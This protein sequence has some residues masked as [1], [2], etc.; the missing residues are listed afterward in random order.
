[1]SHTSQRRGLDP[2]KPGEEL[3]VIAMVPN[4]YR[5]MAEINAAMYEIGTKMLEYSPDN[6]LMKNFTD[7]TIPKFGFGQGIM[8]FLHQYWPE[9][10]RKLLMRGVSKSSLIITAL[11]TDTKK[12]ECLINDLKSEWLFRNRKEG[13][14]ISLVLSGLPCDIHT[15]CEQNKIREHTYLHSLGF[16][17]RQ[18]GI[19]T[20]DKLSLI[21]MCG[22]GLISKNR[23]TYL[24]TQ[25]KEKKLTSREAAEDIAKPCI[26]GI[27]NKKRAEEIFSLIAGK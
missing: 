23:I 22:H 8:E 3:I 12:V 27:V 21:T 15:C 6:W 18:S 26:C 14:P 1:M 7:I 17:G 25:I 19:P 2:A 5:H 4:R 10:T 16:F 13:Y 24:T 9:T 20:A 11:Y